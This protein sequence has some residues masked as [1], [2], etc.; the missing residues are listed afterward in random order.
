MDRRSFLIAGGAS[1]LAAVALPALAEPAFAAQESSGSSRSGGSG[2]LRIR[3][4]FLSIG[5]D[6][7]GRVAGLVDLRNGTDY[8]AADRTGPLVSVVLA[9]GTHEVPARVQAS[10]RDPR[11]LVF[12][13]DKVTV[14]VKA[15]SHAAYSTLEVVGLDAASGVEVQTLLWG[16]LASRVN[17]TVGE[18]VGAVGDSSFVLGIHPLN[19]KTVGAW[20][21]EFAEFGF[22]ADVE[23]NPYGQSGTQNDW[24]AGARTPWGSILRAYTYDYTRTRIRD[25]QIPTGPLSGSEAKI[26]GSKLAVYGSA[27][28]LVLTVL[29]QVAQDADLPYPTID[30]QWQ[31]VAEATRQPFLVLHDLSTTNLAAA[32]AF[33]QQAG[34]KNVYSVEGAAGPWKSTGHY[35]FNGNFGGSDATATQMATTAAASGVRVGVHTL[36]NFIASNDTYIVPAPAD[37]R[38]TAGRTVQLTRPLAA[39]D[40]TLYADG[41]SGGGGYVLGARLRLGDEFVTFSSVS[42]VGSG[43]WQFTGV[44]RAQWG[45]VAASYAQGT[46][47]VR[48]SENQYGGARGDLPV[49]DEIATRLATACNTTGIRNISFDGLEEVAWSGWSGQGFAHMLNGFHRQLKS[50]DNF[51][52]EASNPSSNSWQAQSRVSWGGI[53]WSDSNYD[54]VSRNVNFYR[55]NYLPLM[56]GSLPIDGGSK[57]LDIETNLARGASLGVNFG[58]FETSMGSLSQGG[59]TTAVLAVIK[60]WNAAIAAGAFTSAQQQL[61]ADK[62]KYWHLGEESAGSRWSLQEMDTDNNPVGAPQ[63]VQAPRPGF[64]TPAPPGAKV[65]ELYTFKVTSN[66][67]RTVR[68][69]ITS[70]ALPA[71]LTLNKDTG[72]ITGVPTRSGTRAF[73]ITARN[74]GGVPDASVNHRIKVTV[75]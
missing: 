3:A 75:N 20:P 23:A 30:G 51:I 34:I 16:P 50:Q 57:T 42:Q 14:E 65:G 35:Q 71:G 43:E 6:R 1:S 45:S 38:F 68:Y 18:S 59:N 22:G 39:A 7:T 41:D 60:T 10:R 63:V 66:T 19:D 58:W 21:K 61:M 5:L 33:A 9:D 28:D 11:V 67:P 48:I 26:V 31:K 62:N 49:V 24:S 44:K 27:P 32:V 25:G 15:V 12:S 36:S 52:S 69:E 29:S 2:A 4:G 47:A 54:Q 72:G 8:V 73:A 70:G 40:T 74:G 55:A 53:G 13:S 56:G 64:T 46:N 17:Q 37:K